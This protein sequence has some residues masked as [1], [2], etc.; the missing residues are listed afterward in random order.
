VSE[1]D[2]PP[3]DDRDSAP[4]TAGVDL[5][6][7]DAGTPDTDGGDEPNGNG[8][9]DGDDGPDDSDDFPAEPLVSPPETDG[10]DEGKTFTATVREITRVSADEVPADYPVSLETT[11]VLAARLTVEGT[12][13]PAFLVYF[14]PPTRGP[15]DRIERL[16]SLARDD[17]DDT[18]ALAG[19]SL[20]LTISEGYYVPVV[21]EE[22]PRGTAL[23]VYGVFAG[24]APS[25][26][27]ALVGLFSPGASF[28]GTSQFLLAWAVATF[29]VLPVS[30]YFDAWNL[31]TTTGWR[32]AP[33]KWAAMAAVPGLNVL[34][35]PLYLIARENADPVV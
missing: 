18:D 34:A 31:R 15:D 10:E 17:P 21:P 22:G 24:L 23:A 20:L 1:D 11:Q 3:A 4:A 6:T 28:I 9:T 14:E 12:E 26:L 29:L 35:V 33:R 7:G 5:E 19:R 25:L 30:L 13:T 8:E 27:V 16:L 2:G 32:G